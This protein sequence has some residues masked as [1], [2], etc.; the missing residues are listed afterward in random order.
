M[1]RR[2]SERVDGS[3][4]QLSRAGQDILREAEETDR[5]ED[6]LFGE[7]RGDE[8]PEPLR[9]PATRRQALADAKRRLAERK[10][11]PA[12]E[13]PRPEPEEL[14][15]DLEAAVMGRPVLR[16]GSSGSGSRGA[17]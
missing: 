6:E 15:M 8:L 9:N 2:S 1:R 4:P 14:E 5:R 13:E 11:R 17:S 16:P 12:G 3:E 7:D 10:Q